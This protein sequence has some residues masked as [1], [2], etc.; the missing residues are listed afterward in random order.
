MPYLLLHV[1]K[2]NYSR[3][4][5]YSFGS[6]LYVWVLTYDTD[7]MKFQSNVDAGW[8]VTLPCS[9]LIA[10]NILNVIILVR[11]RK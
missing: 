10:M 1:K 8:Y 5:T 9:E 7:S 4:I 6:V 3:Y 11:Y 2:K